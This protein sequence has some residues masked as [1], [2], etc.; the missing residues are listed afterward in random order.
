MD[1]YLSWQNE[2]PVD[3]P[4][5]SKHI[6]RLALRL[7]Y[8]LLSLNEKGCK[9]ISTIVEPFATGKGGGNVHNPTFF[10]VILHICVLVVYVSMNSLL[11]LYFQA[12]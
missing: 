5:G 12:F 2:R 10:Q 4:S 8:S 9:H 3:N 6:T 7:D 1:S 11:F